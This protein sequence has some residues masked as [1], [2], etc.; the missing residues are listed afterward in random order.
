MKNILIF[1][2]IQVILTKDYW[3]CDSQG[4]FICSQTQTCCK[5]ANSSKKWACYPVIHGVCCNDNR[6]V[7]PENTICN[8]EK[9]SCDKSAS[10]LTF[11]A[12]KP[13]R[14]I[15][16]MLISSKTAVESTHFFKGFFVGSHVFRNVTRCNIN[17]KEAIQDILGIY[18]DLK[19]INSADP[20]LPV[21]EDL[22]TKVVNLHLR[23]KDIFSDCNAF[24]IEGET[25]IN[26]LINYF[27]N[28]NYSI[29]LLEHTLQNILSIAERIA[30]IKLNWNR[31]TSYENG[32]RLGELEKYIFHWNFN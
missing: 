9:Q 3:K 19:I 7:C 2:L 32:E 29:R 12:D 26:N 31:R 23:M 10:F 11:L 4:K 15:S 28:E 18:S 14:H 16:P 22:V 21:L 27:K 17:D 30:D 25:Q 13:S 6:S 5:N 24:Y 8:L 20:I 1:C